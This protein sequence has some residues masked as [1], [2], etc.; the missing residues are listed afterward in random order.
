[1]S[2]SVSEDTRRRIAAITARGKSK[3]NPDVE[4][5]MRGEKGKR[6]CENCGADIPEDDTTHRA[7][8]MDRG[9]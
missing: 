3:V 1:V 2:A 4:A 5:A 6:T 9:G 7:E 8:E